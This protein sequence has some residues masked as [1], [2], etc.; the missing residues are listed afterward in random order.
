MIESIL[1]SIK[2]L[3]NVSSSDT[4]FDTDILTHINSAFSSL[5]QMGIGPTSGFYITDNADNWNDFL[6]NGPTLNLVKTYLTLK[7]RL[8]FDP[9]AT[10]FTISMMKEQIEELENRL[11]LGNELTT[12]LGGE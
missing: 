12:S 7:V 8:L 4:A 11:I 9:P 2:E 3:L 10:S 1:D 5:Y 6:P